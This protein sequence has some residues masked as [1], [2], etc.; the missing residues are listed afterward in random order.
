MKNDLVTEN[1]NFTSLYSAW[2]G[3]WFIQMVYIYTLRSFS[4]VS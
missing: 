2:F 4:S 3:G 1:L